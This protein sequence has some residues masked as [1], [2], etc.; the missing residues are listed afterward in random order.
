MEHGTGGG[1]SREL[2]CRSLLLGQHDDVAGVAFP[3]LAATKTHIFAACGGEPVLVRRLP[4]KHWIL[5]DGSRRMVVSVYDHGLLAGMG[6]IVVW[7]TA[8]ARQ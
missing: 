6:W 5:A 3:I 1:E 2:N 8:I 4:V 7:M